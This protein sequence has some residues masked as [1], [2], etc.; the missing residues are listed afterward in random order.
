MRILRGFR[1]KSRAC[2][3]RVQNG[4]GRPNQEISR[5]EARDEPFC[6]SPH[7]KV[8][9]N[10]HN[11]VSRTSLSKNPMLNLILAFLCGIVTCLVSIAAFLYWFLKPAPPIPLLPQKIPTKDD[12][13]L[14]TQGWLR[15]SSAPLFIND[16]LE[17][18]DKG[19]IH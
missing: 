4:S 17:K 10:T 11:R 7:V 12:P 6:M 18:P 8:Q 16:V 15:I 9:Q 5:I 2:S 19:I 1:L 3:Q 13:H 14:S